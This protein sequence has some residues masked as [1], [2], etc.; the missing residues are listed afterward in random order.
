[1]AATRKKNASSPSKSQFAIYVAGEYTGRAP[2]TYDKCPGD[3]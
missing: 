2:A 3:L 1:M